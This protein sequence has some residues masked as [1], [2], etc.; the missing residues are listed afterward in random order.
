MSYVPLAY[1][2]DVQALGIDVS[3]VT[4]VQSLIDSV[5]AEV[6]ETAG[7]PITV[8]D[9]TITLAGVREQF[10]S[11]PGGP[12]RSV[13]TVTLDGDAVTDYKVRD[14]RLWRLAGWGDVD[15]DVVVTYTHGFD[16]PPADITRLV[17]LMVA[18]G[19]NAAAGGF[20]GHR[21]VAYERDD[22]YQI[23]YQQGQ[24]ENV[25]P[26]ALPDRVKADLRRRFGGGSYVTGVY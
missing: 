23:G 15:E 10:L 3:N 8:T 1:V 17:C 2:T 9:S 4:L 20:A 14:N 6:R 25:D 26:T 11:L 22:T 5:S 21:G 24:D 16:S 18:A 19:V 7:C 12:I 13:T